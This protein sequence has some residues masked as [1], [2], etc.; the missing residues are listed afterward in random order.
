[1]NMLNKLFIQQRHIFLAPGNY[2]HPDFN[3]DG[4]HQLPPRLQEKYN[5]Q[6]IEKYSLSMPNDNTR[7]L[8]NILSIHWSKLPVI[9]VHLGGILQTDMQS[10]S[11][12]VPNMNIVNQYFRHPLNSHNILNLGMS[13]EVLISG[14]AQVLS[15]LAP[16]GH[17]YVQRA[18]YMFNERIQSVISLNN[19]ITLPWNV[20]AATCHYLSRSQYNENTSTH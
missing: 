1:M 14:A 7:L 4:Y 8:P 6:L 20:I 12:K 5:Q 9:A 11:G 19:N 16:F 3:Q 10:W 18:K 17:I 2:I 15:C 13:E